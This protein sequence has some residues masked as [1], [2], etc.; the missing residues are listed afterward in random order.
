VLKPGGWKRPLPRCKRE[1]YLNGYEIVRA[2]ALR[3][4]MD[5][6]SRNAADE[7]E[8]NWSGFIIVE[9]D[10]PW[11]ECLILTVS[12]NGLCLN[13]GAIVVPEIFAVAF[14]PCG[15]VRRVCARTWRRGEL[16]RARF[17]TGTELRS[18]L[19]ANPPSAVVA[20]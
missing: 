1:L 19:K 3:W 2:T 13:V 18:A 8:L 15:S 14:T 17:V 9:P 20:S 12:A 7:I 16:V 10:A 5:L 4:R 6:S 11:I